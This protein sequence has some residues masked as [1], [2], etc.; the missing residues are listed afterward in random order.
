MNG[1]TYV[2]FGELSGM[3]FYKSG[4]TFIVP[5]G[6]NIRVFTEQY[7]GWTSDLSGNEYWNYNEC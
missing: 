5:T 4:P 1:V 3:D 2:A 7:D 6:M